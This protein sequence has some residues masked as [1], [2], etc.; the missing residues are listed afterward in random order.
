MTYPTDEINNCYKVDD[1]GSAERE[2]RVEL[3]FHDVPGALDAEFDICHPVGTLWNII[4]NEMF[5]TASLRQN[6]GRTSW[7]VEFRHPLKFDKGGKPGRKVRKGLG[8]SSEEQ[9]KSLVDQLNVLLKDESLWSE[10]GKSAVKSR[11]DPRVIEIF[12]DNLEVQS[13]MHREI[14]EQ[15]IPFPARGSSRRVLL[16]GRT[17]AGKTTLLRQLIGSDNKSD[18][19]PSTSTNRTTTCE[20]EVISTE[21]NF[22]AVVTF[23]PENEARS[24]VE[25]L[26]SSAILEAINGANNDKIARVFLEDRDQRFRLKYLL[27]DLEEKNNE[28]EDPYAESSDEQK[29]SDDS[30]NKIQPII[31]SDELQNKLKN[32]VRH[33]KEIAALARRK[34]GREIGN[35]ADISDQKKGEELDLIQSEVEESDNFIQLVSE[36]MEEIR[37]KFSFMRSGEFSKSPTG[38]FK[39]WKLIGENDRTEFITAVKYFSANAGTL[40]GTLVSPLVTGIRVQGSFFPEWSQDKHPIVLIDTEGLGHKAS[41]EANLSNPMVDWFDQVDVILLIDKATDS[42]ANSVGKALETIASTGHTQKLMIAFTHMDNLKGDNL[43]S[44][45]AKK[46]HLR[47][48]IRNVI[49]N[50]VQ[51]NLPREVAQRVEVHLEK[52]TYFLGFLDSTKEE[53]LN[54]VKPDLKTMFAVL[55][56]SPSPESS[57][58]FPEY[59]FDNLVLAI[60]DGIAAFRERWKALLGLEVEP[61]IPPADWQSI[62]ALAKN[63]GESLDDSLLRLKPPADLR[64]SLSNVISRFLDTPISWNGTPSNEEKKAVIDQ[65]KA[66]FTRKSIKWVEQKARKKPQRD[67]F[68]AFSSYSMLKNGRGSTRLR[69]SR[70]E[71]LYEHWIPIPSSTGNVDVQEFINEIKI[72]VKDSIN[73]VKREIVE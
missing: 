69:A 1:P 41:L 11:F 9:A 35:L 44:S 59:S 18:R 52:N 36:I 17:G 15:Y 30:D 26:V 28:E 53:N 14:R 65:I 46:D 71:S 47:N 48:S 70:I 22:S 55:I 5:Y 42:M 43:S 62:R 63:Y 33:I 68:E 45:Q 4:G 20:I 7:L 25:E 13:T 60:R 3:M 39:T 50:Q 29:K 12:Y 16:L 57:T 66:R 10:D 32:F 54:K 23:M 73:E 21:K 51:K 67:W 37:S 72:L 19:F 34:I 6:P 8:D 24:K 27:G 2:L 61:A 64:S 40:W 58:A 49:E 56:H 38:W 31:N